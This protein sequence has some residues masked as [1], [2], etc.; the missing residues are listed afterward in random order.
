MKRI[1]INGFGRIGRL[2]FRRLWKL[3]STQIAVVA[4]ND[5][6]STACL[7]NLLKYDS[8]HGRFLVD[9]I[10]YDDQN[11]IVAGQKI[12]VFSE[13]DP[14]KLPW[15]EYKIDLVVESTGLFLKKAAALKH[16]DAGAQKVL[17]S[18]PSPDDVKM[19]VFGVNHHILNADDQ[20][21]SAAS[22]TTNCLALLVDAVNKAF[23]VKYGWMTTVHASTNDQRVLDLPHRDFRRGRSALCN[24]IPTTTGAAK[25]VGKILPSLAGY[26]NGYSIRVPVTSGSIV[27]LVVH[28]KKDASVAAV[29]NAIC[30][31]AINNPSLSVTNDPL[32]SGDVIG[33]THGSI[34][35]L[36]LT[37]MIE[38]E[39]Q[40][41][42]KLFSWYDNEYSYVCQ[43]VRTLNW[44]LNL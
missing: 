19:V 10:S 14:S 3:H 12:R 24:I 27:D 34:V 44:M 21:V 9:K 26:L 25:A 15:E 36:S 17:L 22:C 7:A 38:C 41:L 20:I 40:K 4:I 18:A 2:V 23:S 13:R 35:D 31:Y 37:S 8:T 1:A 32:V 42:F 16:I 43:Y 28:L 39:G 5:L 11:L 29:N 6:T 33:D 30:N